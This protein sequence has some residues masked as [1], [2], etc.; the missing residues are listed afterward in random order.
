MVLIWFRH[1]AHGRGFHRVQR[2]KGPN[3]RAGALVLLPYW[4]QNC[5][6]AAPPS[7]GST[8]TISVVVCPKLAERMRGVTSMRANSTPSGNATAG[9]ASMA[10]PPSFSYAAR[11]R[12][13]WAGSSVGPS[14]KATAIAKLF[15]RMKWEASLSSANGLT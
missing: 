11:T 8:G 10:T 4:T 7:A 12:S 14:K 9:I 6:G 1:L 5:V 15:I 3:R 13:A 2:G